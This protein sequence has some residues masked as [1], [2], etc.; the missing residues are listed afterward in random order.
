MWIRSWNRIVSCCFSGRGPLLGVFALLV[1]LAP[2]AALAQGGKTIYSVTGGGNWSE[3]TTWTYNSTGLYDPANPAH[4]P[5]DG[6]VVVIVKQ[7]S[8]AV[9]LDRDVSTKNLQLD[10]QASAQLNLGG[11]SFTQPLAAL[12]GKGDIL[13]TN[14]HRKAI[15]SLPQIKAGG[16]ALF[17]ENNGGQVIVDMSRSGSGTTLSMPLEIN[18][19]RFKG[20]ET[21]YLQSATRSPSGYAWTAK[22]NFEVESACTVVLD[23]V[24]NKGAGQVKQFLVQGDF[25]VA[26]GGT[27]RLRKGKLSK[28]GAL[29]SVQSYTI[30]LHVH[31]N[32]L[33][34]NGKLL[35]GYDPKLTA[36]NAT[37][38]FASPKSHPQVSLGT[39]YMDGNF[40]KGVREKIVVSGTEGQ[41]ELYA[42]VIEKKGNGRKSKVSVYSDSRRAFRLWG[43]TAGPMDTKAIQIKEGTLAFYSNS[44]IV[45]LSQDAPFRLLANAGLALMESSTL[46]VGS[47]STREQVADIMGISPNQVK[48]VGENNVGAAR[49]LEISGQLNVQKGLFTAGEM[50]IEAKDGSEIVVAQGATLM[51]R[52][53]GGPVALRVDGGHIILR[54]AYAE[55]DLTT[56]AKTLN[57]SRGY[58]QGMHQKYYRD[59]EPILELAQ[60]GSIT[61]ANGEIKLLGRYSDSYHGGSTTYNNSLFNIN[62]G[63]GNGN[64]TGGKIIAQPSASVTM[65]IASDVALYDLDINLS[66]GS[67]GMDVVSDMTVANNVRIRN[68][69]LAVANAKILSVGRDLLLEN[70]TSRFYAGEATLRFYSDKDSHFSTVNPFYQG[71]DPNNRDLQMKALI[72]DKN[73]HALTLSG[74][75]FWKLN[76]D[77]YGSPSLEVLGAST[78]NLGNA[79]LRSQSTTRLMGAKLRGGELMQGGMEILGDP[80]LPAY[81]DLLTLAN[82]VFVKTDIHIGQSLDFSASKYNLNIDQYELRLLKDAV[83]EHAGQDVGT[84]S[85]VA[86]K[87]ITRGKPGDKGITKVFEGYYSAVFI[88]P[89]ETYPVKLTGD[90]VNKGSFTIK[91]VKEQAP[92][93]QESVRDKSWKFYWDVV[94]SQPGWTG[95]EMEFMHFQRKSYNWRLATNDLLHFQS[96][97]SAD[98]K[99]IGQFTKCR[100][101]DLDVYDDDPTGLYFFCYGFFDPKTYY[102]TGSNGDWSDPA[103]WKQDSWPHNKVP[104]AGDRAHIIPGDRVRLDSR[105]NECGQVFVANGA[106]LDINGHNDAKIEFYSGEAPGNAGT[107][108]IPIWETNSGRILEMP[109]T[110]GKLSKFIA[111]KGTIRFEGKGNATNPSTVYMLPEEIKEYWHLELAPAH[112]HKMIFNQAISTLRILGNLTIEAELPQSRISMA[113]LSSR[114]ETDWTPDGALK[115]DKYALFDKTVT[116]LGNLDV[117][118]GTLSFG[119][120]TKQKYHDQGTTQIFDIHGDLNVLSAGRILCLRDQAHYLKGSTYH[121]QIRLLGNL[122]NQ[123][124][125]S[126]GTDPHLSLFADRDGYVELHLLGDKDATVEGG[127]PDAQNGCSTGLG[128]KVF[129]NKGTDRSKT[130]TMIGDREPTWQ[131]GSL[132]LANGTLSL[133]YKQT[134]PQLA[135]IAAPFS[136]TTA[137]G[138]Y[139]IPRTSALELD[140]QGIRVA[141]EGSDS[142]ALYLDGELRILN[143]HLEFGGK[144][145]D[146]ANAPSSHVALQYSTDGTAAIS[147]D[148]QG[149]LT[150]NGALRGAQ[151]RRGMLR[152]TQRG[153]TLF[154]RGDEKSGEEAL[155]L[156]GGLMDVQGGTIQ[157]RDGRQGS[158]EFGSIFLNPLPGSA[159][160]RDAHLSLGAKENNQPSSPSIASSIPLCHLDLTGKQSVSLAAYDMQINGNLTIADETTIFAPTHFNLSLAGNMLCK[161]RY[162]ATDNITRF[163]GTGAIQL[164]SWDAGTSPSRGITAS[165]LQILSTGGVKLQSQG[166]N[167][168]QVESDL[169]IR[170]TKDAHGALYCNAVPLHVKGNLLNQSGYLT[171]PQTDGGVHMIAGAEHTVAGTARYGNLSIEGKTTA[172]NDIRIQ[173]GTLTLQHSF[174]IEGFGVSLDAASN[175]VGGSKDHYLVT[176]GRKSDGGLQYTL[177]TMAAKKDFLYPVGTEKLYTPVT[178][179]MNAYTQDGGHVRINGVLGLIANKDLEK[180][181]QYHWQ[182]AST[183]STT[184]DSPMLTFKAPWEVRGTSMGDVSL[185]KTWFFPLSIGDF[186]PD[187]ERKVKREGGSIVGEWDPLGS[188]LEGWYTIGEDDAFE[189]VGTVISKGSGN[190]TDDIWSHYDEKTKQ[191]TP[192]PHLPT[193]PNRFKVFIRE[194]DKVVMDNPKAHAFSL[195]FLGDSDHPENTSVEIHKKT[196]YVDL[197][198][199]TGAGA[200]RCIN[201]AIPPTGDYT[202]FLSCRNNGM[203]IYDGDED[204]KIFADP[205]YTEIAYLWTLGKKER[206]LNRPPLTVCKELRLG[207]ES[208]LAVEKASR[209]NLQ[210]RI[211]RSN[212]AALSAGKGTVAF[213]GSAL[214]SFGGKIPNETLASTFSGSNAF[215]NVEIANTSQEGVQVGTSPTD[216]TLVEISGQL[217]L[218]DGVLRAPTKGQGKLLYHPIESNLGK[219]KEYIG[220]EDSFV[221][222]RLYIQPQGSATTFRFPM[223]IML[224][225]GATTKPFLGNQ[226]YLNGMSS[227]SIVAVEFRSPN[228][229][230]SKVAFDIGSIDPERYWLLLADNTGG[231]QQPTVHILT[232]GMD[233]VG[234]DIDDLRM[235]CYDHPDGPAG[236]RGLWAKV[237][238]YD[239][240]KSTP[241]YNV[242]SRNGQDLSRDDKAFALGMSGKPRI[243]FANSKTS[244]LGDV[245]QENREALRLVLIP[246]SVSIAD[247]Y[248]IKI[249][250]TLGTLHGP[251]SGSHQVIDPNAPLYLPVDRNDVGARALLVITDF[252][253]ANGTK[254]GQ[255]DRTAHLISTKPKIVEIT[256]SEPSVG[257]SPNAHGRLNLD[258]NVVPKA[259][260][261]LSY[262]WFTTTFPLPFSPSSSVKNPSVEYTVGQRYEVGV[263]VKNEFCSSTAS[264]EIY[265]NLP[266]KGSYSP[267]GIRLVGKHYVS[268]PTKFRDSICT[269]PL[270]FTPSGSSANWKYNWTFSYRNPQTNKELPVKCLAPTSPATTVDWDDPNLPKQGLFKLKAKFTIET[271]ECPKDE[272]DYDF[273]VYRPANAGPVYGT[274]LGR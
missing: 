74:F 198:K 46:V 42:L 139:R 122:S 243:R 239:I 200:L 67:H 174:Y 217:L 210:G 79:M 129:I 136:P 125:K 154:V 55:K 177:P 251:I 256:S 184:M 150:I 160:T 117:K 131:P 235:G 245:E 264:L 96:P 252:Q 265:K 262:E 59:S 163:N 221:A 95:V 145:T 226:L 195:T 250:Y 31:G 270:V 173:G 182:V 12:R 71:N 266:P 191:T 161:G 166:N 135:Y 49:P 33:V 5:Q 197:G 152:Y 99:N 6:D 193:G 204:Y 39:L 60:G 48:N 144:N 240:T 32:V 236:H 255:F 271:D 22:G 151:K 124:Q 78:V 207:G 179:S 148:T 34:N 215:Y 68:G 53:L 246:G 267:A 192:M 83:F 218:K 77:V 89:L 86:G 165:T 115:A 118:R 274:Q 142:D 65:Q 178:L 108:V 164:C 269:V 92:N 47:A 260:E 199:V 54:G 234:T 223:G 107:I 190:W 203:L 2:Y 167:P 27:V 111:D 242:A 196:M 52:Q 29:A 209:I 227:N 183:A 149:T 244:C 7:M 214:Q 162:L 237:D 61:M 208:V 56:L 10:I 213:V 9:I 11:F 20:D 19:I 146:P 72:V 1:L 201:A 35:M 232:E 212:N 159:M 109:S 259:G 25:S 40:A 44:T 268:D 100:L 169:L 17:F 41:I 16:S 261:T 66:S 57:T 248:P 253:Y 189:K 156:T 28:A 93:L 24:D 76:G 64:I 168:L 123:C 132:M 13:L 37:L 225:N 90:L 62:V 97:K 98:R 171:D 18:D 216:E 119:R 222:G 21:Y 133:R 116:I 126:A 101:D 3:A 219:G 172:K 194:G 69:K 140:G 233:W 103:T 230:V 4:V 50:S 157:V 94:A 263:K 175:L 185:S 58:D 238:I 23:G 231:K 153:G 158:T 88:F 70:A 143:G 45:S 206:R 155:E 80:K 220:S 14:P 202:E 106:T 130:V 205:T 114:E 254:H 112:G 36:A 91:L 51:G 87:V 249:S 38:D 138:A 110:K 81:V 63:A 258:A 272:H 224:P 102:S 176:Y 187:T 82:N 170:N 134:N 85:S 229:D 241:P 43:P 257:C 228:E 188:P 15:V 180:A 211:L 273:T 127:L 73:G 120:S 121:D 105:S 75:K 137:S 181:I 141:F 104:Q 247:I 30:G 26:K 8:Q 128:G 113:A 186:V 147:I 84:T